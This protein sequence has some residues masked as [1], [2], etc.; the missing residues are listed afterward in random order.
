MNFL[1]F[2]VVAIVV[3]GVRQ[4]QTE[5]TDSRSYHPT[6]VTLSLIVAYQNVI[7]KILASY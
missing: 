6:L 4:P 2:I 7:G 3:H 1:V 5:P